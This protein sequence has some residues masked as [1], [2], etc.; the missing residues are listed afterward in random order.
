M[1]LAYPIGWVLSHLVLAIAYY[2]VLTPMGWLMRLVGH[3]PMHRAFDQR[4]ASYWVSH[5]PGT[6]KPRYL[7][8]F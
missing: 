3:D 2:L 1:T 4:A 7:R 5:D 6:S 8:Q